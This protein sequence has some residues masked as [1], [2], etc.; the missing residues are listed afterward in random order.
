MS[1]VRNIMVFGAGGFAREVR[2][3]I[4]ELARDG[5]PW[6]FAG[7]VVS[8]LERLGPHDSRDAV[9]GDTAW[10]DAHR[11]EVDAVAIG[12]GTPQAR[13]RVGAMLETDFAG[14]ELPSLVHPSVHYDRARCRF[15][16]GTLVCAGTLA[17]VNVTLERFSM[18]NLG[19]TLGHE[20][21]V[22]RGA[23]LNPSVSLSGGVTLGAGVLVGTGA[24]V[25]QYLSVGEG[26]T[27]GAGAVV[28]RDVPAGE[29]WVGVPAKLLGAKK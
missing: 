25:L 2:W 16:A 3:L 18:V 24:R 1:A 15:E 20:A 23:V 22:G 7:Y 6:R 17:T 13:L 19:C 9:R 8:D 5:A 4:E 28:T 27:V 10:L 29:T 21:A 26:A 12:I 11:G 14:L